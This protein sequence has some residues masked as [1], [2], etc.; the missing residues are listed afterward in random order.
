MSPDDVYISVSIGRLF[1]LARWN[2]LA[3]VFSSRAACD[4]ASLAGLPSLGHLWCCSLL[5]VFNALLQQIPLLNLNK[6]FRSMRL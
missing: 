5:T 4:A 3:A 6:L 1:G 2:V